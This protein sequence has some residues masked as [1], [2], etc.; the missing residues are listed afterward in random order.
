[1]IP[2]YS[3]VSRQSCTCYMRFRYKIYPDIRVTWSQAYVCI[4]NTLWNQL[5]FVL[6]LSI[7]QY[8]WFPSIELPARAPPLFE[9]LWQQY[10]ALCIF[11]TLYYV[12]HI[13]HHRVPF[14]Y[15]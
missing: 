15:K 8:V 13:I 9:F 4:C 14:L 12:W 1:M 7:A 5:L 3:V 2:R 10:A 6:P 11:D